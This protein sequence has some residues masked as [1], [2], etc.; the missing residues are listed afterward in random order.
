MQQWQARRYH[1]LS[2][3]SV[4]Q[5]GRALRLVQM[6][7]M[8]PLQ[9]TAVAATAVAAAATQG[10]LFICEGMCKCR[11]CSMCAT[12]PTSAQSTA[13][14]PRPAI[15]QDVEASLTRTPRPDRAGQ[16]ECTPT[17][18][19]DAKVAICAPF[20][21]VKSKKTHCAM[22][23]CAA[24]AICAD[25]HGRMQLPSSPE[26][27]DV[28]LP[29][30]SPLTPSTSALAADSKSAE[31]YFQPASVPSSQ[32]QGRAAIPAPAGGAHGGHHAGPLRLIIAWCHVSRFIVL[33]RLR[34]QACVW[35]GAIQPPHQSTASL[36]AA[37]DA[38]SAPAAHGL[39][40]P[41]GVRAIVSMGLNRRSLASRAPSA[42]R[43]AQ[44]F[45][46]GLLLLMLCVL[47]LLLLRH[48]DLREYDKL[49]DRLPQPFAQYVR[50]LEEEEGKSAR[51][52]L[53]DNEHTKENEHTR[54]AS[55]EAE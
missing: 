21:N 30:S 10:L 14:T 40:P 53:F 13:P 38:A 41:P 34:S 26:Q 37:Q 39:H 5:A 15:K 18:L 24:C 6:Q 20:C 11:S 42:S 2:V 44:L 17:R 22:C 43:Q 25:S 51:D 29:V 7:S 33:W 1:K 31:S 52:G 19:G 12:P 36:G 48:Y 49:L 27:A 4:V 3:H 47:G 28:N 50:E 9:A 46:S 23:K 45:V 8:R 54:K 16:Q 32:A 55:I 35:T